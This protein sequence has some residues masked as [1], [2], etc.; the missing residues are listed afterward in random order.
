MWQARDEARVAV[1]KSEGVWRAKQ[2]VALEQ[3][4]KEL[5]VLRVRQAGSHRQQ[6]SG[7]P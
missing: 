3:Q 2:E 6:S 4:A 1:E 7:G 5:E